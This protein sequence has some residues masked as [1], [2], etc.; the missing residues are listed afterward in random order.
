MHSDVGGGYPDDSLAFVSLDWMLSEASLANLRFQ[1]AAI[2]EIKRTL[3]ANGTLHDSRR[4]LGAYYRYQPRKISARVEPPDPTTLL[5]QN[6]EPRASALLT[7]V[8]IHDSAFRR[9]QHGTDRYAP[10]VLPGTYVVVSSGDEGTNPPE[11]GAAKRAA[12]QE[13]VWDRVWHKRVNY[14][15]TVAIS[16][17]LMLLP[18]WHVVSPPTSCVGPQCLLTP[19]IYAAGALLPAVAQ[20][21]IDAFAATPGRAV[22]MLAII[23][24]LLRRSRRLETRSRDHMRTLWE[25][26]LGLDAATTAPPRAQHWVRRLRTHPHY[27][28]FFQ[29]MKWTALPAIFGITLLVAS[30]VLVTASLGM[31]VLRVGIWMAEYSNAWCRSDREEKFMTSTQCWPL[32]QTVQAGK[33]YRITVVVSEPWGDRTIDT[34]VEGFGSARMSFVGNLLAPLRRSVSAQWFQ[35]MVKIVPAAGGFAIVPLEM[36]R[37]DVSEPRYTAQFRAPKSGRVYFFVNDVL[38]PSWVWRAETFYMNNIGSATINI[39]PVVLPPVA[40]TNLRR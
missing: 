27:Q 2:A 29:S 4:G 10:I 14:F 40:D 8:K 39:E 15:T 7:S 32:P 24:L 12:D 30:T 18:F 22:T 6:P 33:R 19:A 5:M 34:N 26:S 3:N 23:A 13:D 11:V 16:A 17:Y 21:W 38:L 35:P 25:K 36:Q 20:P 28:R 1:D 9:I 31:G 37:S